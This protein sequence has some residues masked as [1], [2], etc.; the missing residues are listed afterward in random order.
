MLDN[1]LRARILHMHGAM[2]IFST[3]LRV[4]GC[5]RRRWNGRMVGE[6]FRLSFGCASEGAYS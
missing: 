2:I 1:A 5:Q 3:R 4:K 6:S